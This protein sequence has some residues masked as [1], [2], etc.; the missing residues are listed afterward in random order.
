M[1]I[2]FSLCLSSIM[3]MYRDCNVVNCNMSV[4]FMHKKHTSTTHRTLHPCRI[5]QVVLKI[6]QQSL[7]LPYLILLLTKCVQTW[8]LPV[9]GTSLLHQ[10]PVHNLGVW[11]CTS[12][13]YHVYTMRIVHCSKSNVARYHVHEHRLLAHVGMSASDQ[14]LGNGKKRV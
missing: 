14:V 8:S 13:Y 4:A 10:L 11:R 7:M 12:F 1:C 3:H 6:P 9:S 2:L 5:H